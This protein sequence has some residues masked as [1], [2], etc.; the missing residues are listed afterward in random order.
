MARLGF[1]GSS[2]V[3]ED[4]VARRWPFRPRDL[5]RYGVSPA[6]I[7]MNPLLFVVRLD[8]GVYGERDRGYPRVVIASARTDMSFACPY[9]A[10]WLHGL[11]PDEPPEAWLCIKHKAWKPRGGL[12]PTQFLRT[13]LWPKIEDLCELGNWRMPATNLARTAFDFF[14]FRSRVGVQAARDA[15]QLILRSGRCTEQE[16][17]ACAERYNSQQPVAAAQ[18]GR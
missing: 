15:Q 10:L 3:I 6:W 2:Q 18:E 11:L 16:V 5:L 8:R 17:L 1:G 4:V 9:S 13:S 7:G 12:V 14:R